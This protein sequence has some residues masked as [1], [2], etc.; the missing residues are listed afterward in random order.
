MMDGMRPP[1][2]IICVLAAS[3]GVVL[4]PGETKDALLRAII[5]Q[6]GAGLLVGLVAD[7]L[8]PR[9]RRTRQNSQ[10]WYEWLGRR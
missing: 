3:C 1:W 7:F 9:R 5:I 8:W 2:L 6:C 4:W 10:N